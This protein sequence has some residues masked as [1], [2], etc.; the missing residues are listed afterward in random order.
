MP[1]AKKFTELPREQQTA[2]LYM[3][4]LVFERLKRLVPLMFLGS[5]ETIERFF[6]ELWDAGLVKAGGPD[7]EDM[8]PDPKR[9]SEVFLYLWDEGAG[10]YER[11]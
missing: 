2:V 8:F 11:L 3:G 1:P 7:C 4:K 10:G 6:V 5:Q 9:L